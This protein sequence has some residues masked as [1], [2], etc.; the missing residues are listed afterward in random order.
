MSKQQAI[1]DSIAAAN[2]PET[3]PEKAFPESSPEFIDETKEGVRSVLALV[4][5]CD[6]LL[7]LGLT[8]ALWAIFPLFAPLGI[9]F[10]VFSLYN[11]FKKQKKLDELTKSKVP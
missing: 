11:F 4:T 9:I 1:L 2:F 10:I 6:L 3:E 5:L 8:L 7:W